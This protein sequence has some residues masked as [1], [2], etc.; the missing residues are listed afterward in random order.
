M[1]Q[2]QAFFR[3][4]GP[5]RKEKYTRRNWRQLRFAC[6]VNRD[7][8]LHLYRWAWRSSL[9]RASWMIIVHVASLQQISLIVNP[10]RNL[11]G[12]PKRRFSSIWLY[13]AGLGFLEEKGA[14]GERDE[15][16]EDERS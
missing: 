9:R 3:R 7:L 14:C 1:G 10:F 13:S 12:R 11:S 16:D 5:D 4:L 15:D 2:K 8:P 6:G